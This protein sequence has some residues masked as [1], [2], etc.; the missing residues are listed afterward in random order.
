MEITFQ[1]LTIIDTVTNLLEIIWINNKT[2][3]NVAQQFSNC[4][5]A[6]YPWPFRVVHDNGGEFIG[7][8]FQ[9]LL[10]RLGIISVLT[11]V[12]NPQSNAIVE[13]SHH[14]IADIIRVM[15]HV[16]PPNN[17]GSAEAMMD[18]AFASCVHSMRI[19]VNGTLRTSPGALAFNR[20]MMV[21]VPLVHNLMAIRD[22]R[23]KLID[24]N[25]RRVNA[26]R[27]NYNFSVG[28]EVMVDEYDP[29]KICRRK[30]GPYRIVRVFTNNCVRVQLSPHV[31]ETFNIRKLSPYKG[32]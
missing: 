25:L 1:A 22:R 17:N 18:N 12:K 11:T 21:D 2:S 8:E 16:S 10:R 27:I 19:A 3:E 32:I 13:R 9:D 26:K 7:W 15:S 6:R 5:L 29:V 23:Q 4:W 14:T 24:E 31:Q 28:D 30:H 20:D